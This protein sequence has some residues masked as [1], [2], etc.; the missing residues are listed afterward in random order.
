MIN[1]ILHRKRKVDAYW[2]LMMVH[3]ARYTELP[4]M[5]LCGLYVSSFHGGW[6]VLMQ[7]AHP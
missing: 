4:S 2:V 5:C 6:P 3:S 1:E 7:K